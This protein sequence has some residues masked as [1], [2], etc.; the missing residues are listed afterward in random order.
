MIE[1]K[2]QSFPA[3][4]TIGNTET[5]VKKSGYTHFEG[6]SCSCF[7]TAGG[8]YAAVEAWNIK[9]AIFS[10]KYSNLYLNVKFPDF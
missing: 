2:W 9:F 1:G 6:S 8:C 4:A 7:L 5:A 10:K 3:G